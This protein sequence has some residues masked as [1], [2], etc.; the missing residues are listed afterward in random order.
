MI[1]PSLQ[2]LI[3]RAKTNMVN[4]TGQ[5]NPAIDA[6]SSAIAGAIF[7]QYAYQDYLF[8]QINP[9]TANEDWL[10]IWAERVNQ[11]R[12]SAKE[13]EGFAIFNGVQG[14]VSI[15]E[16]TQLKTDDDKYYAV[17]SVTNSSQPVPVKSIKQ[18]QDQ[19]IEDGTALYLVNA[20]NGLNPDT[21]TAQQISSG[22]NIE[23]IEHWR[24]RIVSTFN[25][26][27]AVGTPGDY[28]LWAKT[29][30]ADID[31]A[32]TLDNTPTLGKVTIYIGRRENNPIL[33]DGIKQIAQD[34]LESVRLAGCHV[35]VEH[36][37]IKPIDIA[38]N[39]VPDQTTRDQILIAMQNL[40][41]QKMGDRSDLTP[42]EIILAI[43][44]IT[45]NFGLESPTSIQTLNNNQLFTLGSLTW[46]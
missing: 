10:Y 29:S 2:V 36:P 11:I 21:I 43:T 3:Q 6:L 31:Y 14:T 18:G 25:Q 37:V 23:D 15:P 35:F 28:Q 7:G 34:Y 20:I 5:D 19:N 44:P 45:S 17:T 12:I 9:E 46:N 16:G 40:F 27:Q 39:G 4:A 32:W 8:Q 26:R 42:S 33:S 22:A 24:D 13:S 30:H 41:I 38:I 1:K